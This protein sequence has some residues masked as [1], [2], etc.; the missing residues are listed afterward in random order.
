MRLISLLIAAASTAA[1]P[2]LAQQ[3]LPTSQVTIERMADGF[4][5]P[6]AVAILPEGGFL[7][8]E[9]P[10]TLVHVRADGSRTDVDGVPRVRATGQGGLLDVIIARDFDTSRRIYMTF[11]KPQG[12]LGRNEGTALATAVL[13]ADGTSLE[14]VDTIWEMQP[15]SG[16]GFHFG[17]RVVEAPDGTLF[18]TIGDRGDR[19]TAQDLSVHNGS[20]VRVTPTGAVPSDNPFVGQ[21]GA[22]DEIWSYGHRNPQGATLDLAGNLVTV[23]HGAAGGDEINRI[24]RGANYGWPVISYGEHYSGGQIGEGTA[25]EGME[26]PAYYWDPSMA[27]S[28]MMI[29]SGALWPEWE[30]DIFV[31]SLKFS[32]ISVLD[33]DPLREHTQ[34][35]GDETGR[36]R[37]V[38]EAPD[39][40]IWFISVVDGAVYRMTP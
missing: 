7:V 11:A 31:G 12:L 39:G 1:L 5:E 27:P 13:S 28:G 36:V 37:D 6:W 25:K 24:T 10:G 17:S 30:G 35:E 22:L 32:Y 2:A 3:T 8:S 16:G 20:V 40:S 26:Q 18:V 15:G 9:R 21:S 4:D 19:P 33:G 34:I 29:Y 23:E 14:D 38:R